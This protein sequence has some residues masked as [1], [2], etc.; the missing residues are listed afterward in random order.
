EGTEAQSL[1]QLESLCLS[2][3]IDKDLDEEVNLRLSSP[4][5][6]VGTR[7][8]P[9]SEILS[10]GV[11]V[12]ATEQVLDENLGL[13]TPER[14]PFQDSDMSQASRSLPDPIDS[15]SSSSIVGRSVDATDGPESSTQVPCDIAN[16]GDVGNDPTSSDDRLDV[17]ASG[18]LTSTSPLASA[19]PRLDQLSAVDVRGVFGEQ[20]ETALATDVSVPVPSPDSAP[21]LDSESSSS[22]PQPTVR[23]SAR[24]QKK[25]EEGQV[26]DWG[27]LRTRNPD[28]RIHSL[29]DPAS[30]PQADELESDETYQ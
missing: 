27:I 17:R 2:I 25:R 29:W 6:P 7:F 11:D 22:Q 8:A 19:G 24:I 23:R 3:Q 26:R 18:K 1:Q 15:I 28:R 12:K 20:D 4:P 9:P 10:S 5:N 13:L 16:V 30:L 21:I 14:T